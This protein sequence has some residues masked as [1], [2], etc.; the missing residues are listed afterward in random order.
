[1]ES[2]HI[3]TAMRLSFTHSLWYAFE[4]QEQWISQ[5]AVID[6]KILH[7][8]EVVKTNQIIDICDLI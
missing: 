2:Y 4:N 8:T 3:T 7:Y 6:C 5:L 1:M